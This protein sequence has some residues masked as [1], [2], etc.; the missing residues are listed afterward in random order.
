MKRLSA[1]LTAGALVA[2]AIGCRTPTTEDLLSSAGFRLARADTPGKLAHLHSLPPHTITTVKRNDM[3]F[4]VFPDLNQNRLY[5]GRQEQYQK[6]LTERELRQL[7][8]EPVNP[9]VPNENTWALWG[10]WWGPGWQW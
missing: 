1:L 9:A 8:E 6:Y 4:Y 7:P 10:P 5:V 3:R 2:L